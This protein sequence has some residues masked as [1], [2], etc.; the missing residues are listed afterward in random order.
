MEL[1]KFSINIA[2]VDYNVG[3]AVDSLAIAKTFNFPNPQLYQGRLSSLEH[4]TVLLLCLYILYKLIYS[5]LP[6]TTLAEI[7]APSS[8]MVNRKFE[9]SVDE[10]KFVGHP[11][12]VQNDS[13]SIS[14]N[15][16]FV[17]EVKD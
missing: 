6:P 10:W 13:F 11:F 7:L 14:F 16:V 8:L 5:V 9:L 17:L 1:I 3:F 12:S 15:V 2:V 4:V